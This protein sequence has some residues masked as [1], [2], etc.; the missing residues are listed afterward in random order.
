[1]TR[2]C[3]HAWTVAVSKRGFVVV[4]RPYGEKLHQRWFWSNPPAGHPMHQL[5]SGMWLCRS[6]PLVFTDYRKALRTAKRLN[7][8][9]RSMT[10][11]NERMRQERLTRQKVMRDE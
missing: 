3:D 2:R 9:V 10:R 8:A 4:V 7:D 11:H 6:R 5:H 1:M